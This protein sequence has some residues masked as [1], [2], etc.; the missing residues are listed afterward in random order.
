[1]NFDK[2]IEITPQKFLKFLESVI[3]SLP[4]NNSTD[5]SHD[6]YSAI[7]YN[8][9]L[10]YSKEDIESINRI[11][12]KS[13]Y[14]LF[15]EIENPLLFNALLSKGCLEHL[16]DLSV[17]VFNEIPVKT[18][19][20]FDLIYS[21]EKEKEN[22]NLNEREVL[23]KKLC[24][25]F[26]RFGNQ[27]KN[28]DFIF[29]EF[30]KDNCKDIL[31]TKDLFTKYANKDKNY[32]ESIS[33]NF[34]KTKKSFGFDYVDSLFE[35]FVKTTKSCEFDFI[36][37]N[38]NI[39][40]G[41]LPKYNGKNEK[42]FISV[43]KIDEIKRLIDVGFKFHTENYIFNNQSIVC[44]VIDSGRKDLIDLIIPNLFTLKPPNSNFEKQNQMIESL[45]DM[46]FFDLKEYY[47]KKLKEEFSESVDGMLEKKDT[48]KQDVSKLKI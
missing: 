43:L 12:E 13:F 32:I 28:K 7:L 18:K 35:N 23:F 39:L 40:N 8:Q 1:M 33:E 30:L 37:E 5:L 48:V 9:F 45:D 25:D 3:F 19:H 42:F 47:F 10:Q 2:P 20:V 29:K 41:Y 14:S 34:I 46:R 36:K 22:K 11:K 15:L 31:L 38:K 4:K 16:D 26:L 44:A 21:F 17:K 24:V 27:Q 6:G